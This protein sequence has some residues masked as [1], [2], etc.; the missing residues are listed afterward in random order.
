MESLLDYFH[1]LRA[2]VACYTRAYPL[3]IIS[4]HLQSQHSEPS[5]FHSFGVQSHHH[6]Q[7]QHLKLSSFSVLAFRAIIASRFSA[8]RAIVTISSQFGVQSHHCFP[9]SAFKVIIAS[10]FRRSEP[11]SFSVSTFRVIIASQFGV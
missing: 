5:L 6:S 4:L 7:F 11:S 10:Q 3:F 9:I 8:F 2:V 1:G